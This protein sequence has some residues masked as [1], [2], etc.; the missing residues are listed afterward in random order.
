MTYSSWP[1]NQG[2]MPTLFFLYI[3]EKC[4]FIT[5]VIYVG[6]VK[7]FQTQ[8]EQFLE[9]KKIESRYNCMDLVII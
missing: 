4:D 7:Y 9:N 6:T 3:H 2:P 1:H 5:Y 8:F